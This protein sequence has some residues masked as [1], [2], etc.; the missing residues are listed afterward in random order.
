MGIGTPVALLVGMLLV[1]GAVG[2]FFFDKI[3]PAYARDSDKVYAAFILVAGLV[4]LVNWGMEAGPSFLMF[5]MS[6]MLTTLLIENI[7]SR[8]PRENILREPL[9]DRRPPRSP[10]YD[11]RPPVRRGYRAELDDRSDPRPEFRDR[12]V[13]PRMNPAPAPY[14]QAAYPQEAYAN[15]Q[16]RPPY[17][18]Y[19]GPAGQLQPSR[20]GPSPNTG[21]NPNSGGPDSGG[22]NMPP[23]NSR[24]GAD[25]PPNSGYSDNSR[26]GERPPA[27]QWSSQ[28]PPARS[29]ESFRGPESAPRPDDGP[30]Q[31]RP[32]QQERTTQGR[33]GERPPRPAGSGQ[34][35]GLES[36]SEGGPE[37]G[38]SPRA[39]NIRPLSEAPM[40]DENYRPDSKQ[41]GNPEG[42]PSQQH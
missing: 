32:R 36:G 15:R 20:P 11:E 41:N 4:T 34:S 19:R 17:E 13:Q 24:Y 6:G 27:P 35:N 3:R 5:V 33:V 9:N 22:P 38:G 29:P 25:T 21:P 37:G 40:F 42:T 2:L 8:D 14:P 30:R 26:Y 12:P 16:V 31:D 28:Q 39:L 7:R 23:S 10:R 18:E 1:L